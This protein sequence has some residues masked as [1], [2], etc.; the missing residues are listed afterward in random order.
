MKSSPCFDECRR[1]KHPDK[2]EMLRGHF[3]MSTAAAPSIELA[4]P[5]ADISMIE[6]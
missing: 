5:R 2:Q 1:E 6:T 3:S 4:V